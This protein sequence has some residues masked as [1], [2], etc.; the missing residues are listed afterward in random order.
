MQPVIPLGFSCQ[1]WPQCG[2]APGRP[3]LAKVLETELSVLPIVMCV[4]PVETNIVIFHLQDSMPAEKF[5]AD[6][7]AKGVRAQHTSKHMIRLV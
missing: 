1:V 2:R 7:K 4:V 6:L 3:P 5:S